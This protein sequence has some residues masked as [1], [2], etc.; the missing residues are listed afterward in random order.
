MI[1][2]ISNVFGVGTQEDASE[3][4][5]TLL[6]SMAK[7]IKFTPTP[8]S[9]PQLNSNK[10][11]FNILDEIFHF[12]SGVEVNKKNLYNLLTLV[13]NLFI[14]K[15]FLSVTCCN[16]GRLSDTF[17]NTNSWPVDVKV[18]LNIKTLFFWFQLIFFCSNWLIKI[19]LVRDWHSKRYAALS[20]R[21]STRRWKC[22]QMR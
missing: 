20:A 21:R 7:S 6:E 15:F 17:E 9:S 2:E 19:P 10:S 13:N 14:I 4:F 22:L 16:C 12:N 3:F 5:T 8:S 11:T 1:K 18:S